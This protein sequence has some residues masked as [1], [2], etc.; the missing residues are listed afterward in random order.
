MTNPRVTLAQPTRSRSLW[1]VLCG[2]LTLVAGCL[3]T[4]A[5]AD[6]VPPEAVQVE[7][8]TWGGMCAEG[9]C[10]SSLVV[11]AEGRW[12]YSDQSGES[13]GQFTDDQQADLSAAVG[14]TG[15]SGVAASTGCEAD[16]DGTSVRYVWSAGDRTGSAS[17]CGQGLDE[18]DPLVVG[19]ESLV[20][21]LGLN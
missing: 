2:S 21:D 1:V 20:E 9:P 15:L 4:S 16:S 19:V 7:R 3:G 5:P 18:D 12:T 6:K 11:T 14:E 17:T 8:V 10:E 13:D